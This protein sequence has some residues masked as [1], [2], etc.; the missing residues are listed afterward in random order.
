[1][2]KTPT[3]YVDKDRDTSNTSGEFP[4]D[5]DALSAG[6]FF[7]GG[8]QNEDESQEEEAEGELEKEEIGTSNDISAIYLQNMA[9]VPLLSAAREVELAKQIEEGKAQVAEAAL[10]SRL[11]WI[12]ILRLREGVASGETGLRDIVSGGAESEEA[13][14]SEVSQKDFIRK[15]ARLDRLALAYDR[16]QAELRKKPLG[17]RAKQSRLQKLSEIRKKITRVLQHLSLSEAQIKEMAEELKRVHARLLVLEQTAQTQR[18]GT[19]RKSVSEIRSIENMVDLSSAD[20]KRLVAAVL[21]GEAKAGLARKEFIEANLRLVVSLAKKYVNRGLQF[22]DLIQEGNLGLMRAVEKYDYRLGFRFSTYA[23]WWIRQ[24]ITRGIID[25]GHTIRVPVH[26]IETRTKVIRTG[27][28]LAQ[29]LGRSPLPEEIAKEAGLPVEEIFE[30]NRIGGEPISLDTPVG[31]EEESRIADF[32]A[33]KTTPKPMDE[34]IEADLRLGISKILATLTPRE[35]TILRH[36]FGI[37]GQRDYTLEEL[38]ERF[39]VTRERIR[40]IEQKA[41]RRLRFHTRHSK[42]NGESQPST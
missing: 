19:G 9:S 16:V 40:Q 33:D 14:D 18:K 23:S 27:Q 8:E 32:V 13:F 39:S 6:D 42:V 3:E 30:V 26:R 5:E 20:I 7:L 22:L 17:T 2:A 24:S 34:A 15:L 10:S 25:T 36:R 11:A 38:G 1:M 31:D 29:K 12:H 41:I 21:E 35:E 37:D 4:P 28:Y